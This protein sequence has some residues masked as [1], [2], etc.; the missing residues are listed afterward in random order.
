MPVPSTVR[1]SGSRRRVVR[2]ARPTL[3]KAYDVVLADFPIEIR[4]AIRQYAETMR[5]E[6][7]ARSALSTQMTSHGLRWYQVDQVARELAF[8]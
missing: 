1:P 7:D 6:F 4:P 8:S 5:A 2:R 3:D